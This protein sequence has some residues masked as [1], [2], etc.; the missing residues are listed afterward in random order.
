MAHVSGLVMLTAPPLTEGGVGVQRDPELVFGLHQGASKDQDSPVLSSHISSPGRLFLEGATR[1]WLCFCV[2]SEGCLSSPPPWS[3]R[4]E[5]SLRK[6][7]FVRSD[8]SSHGFGSALTKH[9]PA[10]GVS[11]PRPLGG[12][13]QR[14][15]RLLPS[16]QGQAGARESC[17]RAQSPSLSPGRGHTSLRTAPRV[18]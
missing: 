10:A 18:R 17:R 9:F 5:L 7:D 15:R 16:G 2:C 14:G 12:G 6:P 3:H 8:A 11:P 13:E 1:R 4:P